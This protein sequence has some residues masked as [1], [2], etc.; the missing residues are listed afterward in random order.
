MTSQ[1]NDFSAS[2]LFFPCLNPSLSSRE[3]IDSGCC[4]PEGPLNACSKVFD[5]FNLINAPSQQQQSPFPPHSTPS[6]RLPLT[7]PRSSM[8]RD[9]TTTSTAKATETAQTGG[10]ASYKYLTW[11]EKDR[12]RR[13]REEWKHLWLVVP[14]GMYE[15]SFGH[16]ILAFLS[17]LSL[18]RYREI[19]VTTELWDRCFVT[20]VV[21]VVAIW[22]REGGEGQR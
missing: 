21:V 18:P 4:D 9:E 8:K 10:G 5:T 3:S 1:E 15:V 11:R 14:H 6:K 2:R 13:F 22:R 19:W 7:K 16:C 17:P 12:R 20:V